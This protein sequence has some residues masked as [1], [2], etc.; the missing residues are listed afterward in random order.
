MGYLLLV[1]LLSLLS[2][3]TLIVLV[4]GAQGIKHFGWNSRQALWWW[5]GI[6]A[7]LLG[8]YVTSRFI[9]RR[10]ENMVFFVAAV[11][12]G[13]IVGGLL[14]VMVRPPWPKNPTDSTSPSPS[15]SGRP[16]C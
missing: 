7:A 13:L 1:A 5:N 9:P 6:L 16:E 14:L 12:M 10:P 15:E 2:M 4:R 3:G 11:G 8:A